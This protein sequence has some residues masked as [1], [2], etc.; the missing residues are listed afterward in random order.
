MLVLGAESP[1]TIEVEAG[2]RDL[3]PP[4]L[5]L[6]VDFPPKAKASL[7]RIPAQLAWASTPHTHG[8]LWRL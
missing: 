2:S 7:P 5:V 4:T 8:P 1:E 3:V 6:M